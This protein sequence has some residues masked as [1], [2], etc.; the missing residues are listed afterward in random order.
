MRSVCPSIGSAIA[1]HN[2]LSNEQQR[3]IGDDIG[4][5][6]WIMEQDKGQSVQRTLFQKVMFHVLS[7]PPVTDSVF[8]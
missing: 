4:N 3:R 6:R 8:K 5:Q 1:R 7:H 2:S